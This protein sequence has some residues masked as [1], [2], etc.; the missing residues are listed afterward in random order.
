MVDACDLSIMEM[1][2]G[3]SEVQGPPWL[4]SLG[5]LYKTQRLGLKESNNNNNNN[6]NNMAAKLPQLVMDF[7]KHED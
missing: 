6:N 4:Y 3:R 5:Y 2:A 1:G 7:H